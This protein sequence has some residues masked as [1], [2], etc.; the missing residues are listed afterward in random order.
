V[1]KETGNV[2]WELPIAHGIATRPV[3]YREYLIFGES[4]GGLQV[5]EASS[6]K[7]AVSFYP[8]LGVNSAP[9]AEPESNHVFFM[10]NQG[11]LYSMYLQ[12][13]RMDSWSRR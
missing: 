12:W 9:L 1:K 11:N 3:R 13:E 2:I 10:S 7:A 6:G 8:R 5:V 4:D